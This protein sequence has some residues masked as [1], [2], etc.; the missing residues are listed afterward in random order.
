M[1]PYRAMPVHAHTV[2]MGRRGSRAFDGGRLADGWMALGHDAEAS[3]R[4]DL[5]GRAKSAGRDRERSV[6][7]VGQPADAT[8]SAL[9][10]AGWRSWC[11]SCFNSEAG[12][13]D[14]RR[15]PR[16]PARAQQCGVS[17]EVLKYWILIASNIGFYVAICVRV[18]ACRWRRTL[19]SLLRHYDAKPTCR[20]WR[21][22]EHSQSCDP[23]DGRSHLVWAS[24][25][26]AASR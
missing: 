1:A 6:W 13:L 25:V 3:E 21:D 7:S 10:D 17:G 12:R 9:P 19:T 5:S 16:S 2:W 20:K 4:L 22:G 14:R 8:W 11:V 18:A 23:I 15:A 24:S 26:R